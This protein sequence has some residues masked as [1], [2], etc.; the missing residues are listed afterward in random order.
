MPVLH[1]DTNI[2]GCE[3]GQVVYVLLTPL[4]TAWKTNFLHSPYEAACRIGMEPLCTLQQRTVRAPVWYHS[5]HTCIINTAINDTPRNDWMPASHT[6]GQPSH[7]AGIQP[8]ELL[9][10]QAMLSLSCRPLVPGHLLTIN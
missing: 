5:V 9:R 10:R 6:I 8:A 1:P 2:P 4:G 3:T 7:L